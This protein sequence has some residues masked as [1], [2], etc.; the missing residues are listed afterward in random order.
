MKLSKFFLTLGALVTMI[1]CGSDDPETSQPIP[2]PPTPT[3]KLVL[4]ASTKAIKDS[5]MDY[6]EFTTKQG[7]VAVTEGV[8]LYMVGVTRPLEAMRFSSTRAGE[9]K[10]YAKLKDVQSEE[11]TVNV[12]GGVPELPADAQPSNTSFRRR[13]MALQMTGT[14]CPNCPKMIAG[15]RQFM[16]TA[17]ADKALF[18]AIHGFQ[19]DG[20]LYSGITAAISQA[21]G[22]GSF[23]ALTLN[24][25]RDE[26]KCTPNPAAT[27]ANIATAINAEWKG[28]AKAGISVAAVR[29]GGSIVVNIAV[30][31]AVEGSYHVGA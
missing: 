28:D 12:V 25:R 16:T 15:I 3:G 21:Y 9:Y 29:S 26:I 20:K 1:S 2:P 11:V 8:E 18:T 10:F 22:T 6:C 13:V 19:P 17:D 27:T 5:G 14:T 30:K 24:M 7:D 4:T 23:P 31:A